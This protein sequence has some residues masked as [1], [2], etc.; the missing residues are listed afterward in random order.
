MAAAQQAG[1]RILTRHGAQGFHQQHLHQAR[2]HQLAAGAL[3]LLFIADQAYQYGQ[4]TG[5]AHMHQR[6]KQGHQ[7]GRIG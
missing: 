3:C 5:I 1:W 4:A 6:R 7:Q 2:E